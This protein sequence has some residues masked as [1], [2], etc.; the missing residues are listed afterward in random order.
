VLLLV[1]ACLGVVGLLDYLTGYQLSF[2]VFYLVPVSLAAWRIGRTAGMLTAAASS[3]T[4]YAVEAA[5]NPPYDHA[6]IGV[7]NAG[8][9]LVFFLVISYLLAA[10]KDRLAAETALARTD[11]LTGLGN[12]RAFH[13]ALAHDLALSARTADPIALAFVDLDD[14]KL[15]NDRHGHATGDRV[16]VR[17]ADIISG[18]LR[19][20]DT[21]ARLGGDEFALIL[22]ATDVVDARQV[23]ASLQ[24]AIRQ[25]GH[26]MPA[27]RCSIGA[28]VFVDEVDSP[29]AALAVADRLMYAA[30]NR[31]DVGLVV[32]QVVSPEQDGIAPIR[33]VG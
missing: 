12:A 14:F 16:L 25:P 4:W 23:L 19:R 28:A 31:P 29:E 18:S 5:V 20:S 17:V 27:I 6:A 26:D 30:K 32:E 2:S 8:V 9:R 1:I 3:L 13:D 33:G 10:F 7:W 21:A 11:A 22:P 24:E 15:V